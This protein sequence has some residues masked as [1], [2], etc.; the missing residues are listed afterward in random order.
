MCGRY[1]WK[2]KYSSDPIPLIARLKD[3]LDTSASWNIA[4]THG[5]PIIRSNPQGDDF[6]LAHWGLIPSW[7]K[8]RKFSS[9]MINARL[10]SASSKPAFRDSFRRKR[11]LVPADGYYEWKETSAG[12]KQPYAIHHE[13]QQSF[14]MAGLWDA[15]QAPEGPEIISF[16]ILTRQASPQLAQLHHRMP[17]VLNDEGFGS[18]LDPNLQNAAAIEELIDEYSIGDH[19]QFY[20]VSPRVNSVKYNDAALINPVA[21][22]PSLFKLS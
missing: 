19:F 10:E 12:A 4:P 21:I 8:D 17:V 20:P 6:I 18:W 1:Y 9:N 15:W 22:Q 2:N 7:S 14:F 3:S 13:N 5:A 11:C 16:S